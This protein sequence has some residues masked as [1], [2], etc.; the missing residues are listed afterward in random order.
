MWPA[1]DLKNLSG[2]WDSFEAAALMVVKVH[3]TTSSGLASR[4]YRELRT[5]SKVRGNPTPR[6]TKVPDDEILTGLRKVGVANASKQLSLGRP[7]ETVKKATLVNLSG[8]VTRSVLN[9]GRR[10]LTE[11]LVADEKV[12]KVRAR[13]QRI[14]SGSPCSWCAE[15]AGVTYPANEDFSAHDHCSCYP[16]PVYL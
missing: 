4:F 14:T 12:N 13:M 9:H 2:S 15:R 7:F 8:S 10:T 16:S 1:L 5:Q 3:G 11:S 6:L